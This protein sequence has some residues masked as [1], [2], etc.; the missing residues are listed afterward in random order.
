MSKKP[1][2]DQCVKL[3][4]YAQQVWAGEEMLL[5]SQGESSV[6]VSEVLP[7][8]IKV[9]GAVGDQGSSSLLWLS[10]TAQ[11]IG[12]VNVEQSQEVNGMIVIGSNLHVDGFGIKNSQTAADSFSPPSLHWG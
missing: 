12:P 2:R 10:G 9:F 11:S 7:S 1:G 5:F 3:C 6:L 4:G 8:F